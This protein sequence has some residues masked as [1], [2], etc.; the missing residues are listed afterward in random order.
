MPDSRTQSYPPTPGDPWVED[1]LATHASGVPG[2][3]GDRFRT[4]LENALGL[5]DSR[6]SIDDLWMRF[7]VSSGNAFVGMNPAHY[8]S[9]PSSGGGGGGGDSSS[10]GLSLISAGNLDLQPQPQDN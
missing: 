10:L 6:L 5:P 7:I 8:P 4:G 2:S 1:F 3:I 9:L